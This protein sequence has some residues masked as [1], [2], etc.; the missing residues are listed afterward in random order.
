MRR[1]LPVFVGC[2]V[3]VLFAGCKSESE[4]A[5]SDM[6]DKQKEVVKILKT[7]KDKDS[8][9]AAKAKLDA[10][11][12]DMKDLETRM[13]KAKPSDAEQKSLE[14]KYAPELEQATKDM[15]AEMQRIMM[16]P[17][18]APALAGGGFGGFGGG[19]MMR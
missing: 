1:L 10:M 2:L 11:Q 8:A 6:V 3:L 18:L 19:G 15:M 9:L 13:S 7:V 4:S 17:E 14:K 12:K 5:I 16:N